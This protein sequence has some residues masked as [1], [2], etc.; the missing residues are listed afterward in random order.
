MVAS[1]RNQEAGKAGAER[2]A[3]VIARSG[4][5]SRREAEGLI[6]DRRVSVN[7]TLIESAALDILPSDAVL[8][9]GKPLSA[10]EPPRLW[11]YH[12]PKGRVTTHKDPEGRSTVFEALPESLPRLISIGR[13]DFNTEG[14]LLLTNDGDLARHL[15]LPSTGWTRRYRVRAYGQVSEAQLKDL[16][17]GLTINKMSYGPIEASLEREQGDNVWISIS[18]REGKN[19]EVRRIMEHLDLTVNRLIRI[20]FGPFMLGD[21]ETGQIEEVKTA[22]LKDQLGPRLSRQLGVRREIPR[23]ERRLVPG[24]AKPTYLRRKPAAEE[25]PRRSEPEPPVLKRRRIFQQ[26]DSEA[27]KVEFGAER[28]PRGERFARDGEPNEKAPFRSRGGAQEREQRP[29]RFEAGGRNAPEAEA[30][31]AEHDR[32]ARSRHGSSFR[33]TQDGGGQTGFAGANSR[34]ERPRPRWKTGDTV[35]AEGRETSGAGNA[36]RFKK[37]RP[38]HR[39]ERRPRRFEA[40]EGAA[41]EHRPREGSEHRA[42]RPP[43]RFDAA[44]NAAPRDHRPREAF[45]RR[46]DR[47]RPPRRFEAAGEGAQ[48]PAFRGAPDGE[49][50]PFKSR[51][52]GGRRF[53]ESGTGK[54][55]GGFERQGERPRPPRRFEDKGEGAAHERRPREGFE[56]QGERPRPPRRFE[57]K[58][59]GAAD[60]RSPRGERDGKAEPRSSFR[61]ADGGGKPFKTRNA[62]ERSSGRSG[63]GKPPG[64]R[65]EGKPFRSAGK[66]AHARQSAAPRKPRAKPGTD[67]DPT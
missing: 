11:R 8:V 67:K 46:D 33:K 64:K 38:D 63:A 17:G 61:R 9:D 30:P 18:I 26:G 60:E 59:E 25:R 32:P 4:L 15:E 62:G 22:V 6:E 57:A 19:R 44:G 2:V 41:R 58:G 52:A 10:P 35:P 43:R 66:P 51:D 31:R 1:N 12:K 3:K 53:G 37:V 39:E 55:H 21:L 7:G 27:P 48:R 5:C 54:P 20:S 14:L 42:Q 40:G 47:P 24:R 49:R 36:P 13:L 45:E 29:R 56:R 28:K 16:E 50:K 23:E 34:A 65:S